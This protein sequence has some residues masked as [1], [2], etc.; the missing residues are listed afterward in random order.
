[1]YEIVICAVVAAI[2]VPLIILQ[3]R[4][5]KAALAFEKVQCDDSK[6]EPGFTNYPGPM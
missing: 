3:H 1:M 6:C 4:L 2:V 5:S